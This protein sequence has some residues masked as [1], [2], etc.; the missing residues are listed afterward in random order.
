MSDPYAAIRRRH[1]DIPQ[2]T[3]PLDFS[4]SESR[5]GEPVRMKSQPSIRFAVC[6]ACAHEKEIGVVRLGDGREV[7]REHR[8]TLMRGRR[9]RCSGSGTDAPKGDTR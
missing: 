9:I 6:P 2:D 7:F 1:N 8:K 5:S 4:G 3:L